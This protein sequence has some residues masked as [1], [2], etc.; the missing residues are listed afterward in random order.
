MR[1]CRENLPD[2]YEFETTLRLCF[3]GLLRSVFSFASA[4]YRSYMLLCA[5]DCLMSYIQVFLFGVSTMCIGL[6]LSGL[7]LLLY[8]SAVVRISFLGSELF[9]V[10]RISWI[11]LWLS[12]SAV[13]YRS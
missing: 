11:F 2:A 8:V 12:W 3:H 4:T 6:D 1:S 9:L 5:V 7:I 13:E 10:S